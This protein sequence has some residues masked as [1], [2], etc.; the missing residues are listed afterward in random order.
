MINFLK[1]IF[2]NITYFFLKLFCS[3]IGV[4][5]LLA[6]MDAGASLWQFIFCFCFCFFI[7]FL[8]IK[9]LSSEK[10]ILQERFLSSFFLTGQ[11]TQNFSVGISSDLLC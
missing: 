7:I 10:L 6:S 11:M 3:F 2:D 9:P 1:E 5:F 4:F 8:L